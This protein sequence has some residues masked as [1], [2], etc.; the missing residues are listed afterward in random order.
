VISIEGTVVEGCHGAGGFTI[1][2]QMPCFEKR[3]PEI[4]G[5]RPATINLHLDRQ[6]QVDNP[7]S[8]F[9]CIWRTPQGFAV[10]ERF[11]FMEITIKFPIGT[12]PRQAWI[13]IPHDSPH[14]SNR[15]QVEIISRDIIGIEY[16]SRCRINLPRGNANPECIVV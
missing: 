5:S 4:K 1:A 6:L 15:F 3:I 11:G 16:G 7:D 10:L 13:Y 8:E 12:E 2:A 14:R 9:D